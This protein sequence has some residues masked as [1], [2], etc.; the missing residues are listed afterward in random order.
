VTARHLDRLFAER[1]L[2][3]KVAQFGDHADPFWLRSKDGWA[4]IQ[5]GEEHMRPLPNYVGSLDSAWPGV[6]KLRNEWVIELRNLNHDTWL[7]EL[8]QHRPTGLA[9]DDPYGGRWFSHVG[10]SAHPAEALVLA[11]LRAVGVTDE[12][13]A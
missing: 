10:E 8:A 2:G 4:M 3:N 1:V 9:E 7:A 11:A 13:M 12:E 6:E 5:P